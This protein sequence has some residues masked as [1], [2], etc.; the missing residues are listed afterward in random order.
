MAIKT[1]TRRADVSTG[2]DAGEPIRCRQGDEGWQLAVEVTQ[3]GEPLDLTGLTATLKA[4][5]PGYVSIPMTVSGSVAT[6]TATSELTARAGIWHPY[7]E[8]AQGETVVGTTSLL[9]LRVLSAADMDAEQQEQYIPALDQALSTATAASEAAQQAATQ[10]AQAVEDAQQAVTDAQ[11]AVS[12]AN[13][14]AQAANAAASA[15]SDAAAAA[16]GNV[17]VGSETGR[18]VAVDDAY[19]AKPR[20][21][22]VE[23]RTVN[24]LWVNPTGS[25]YGVTASETVDGAL[26]VSGTATTPG[27]TINTGYVY[28]LR[29]GSKITARCDRAAVA[30]MVLAVYFFDAD[31]SSVGYFDAIT[32]SQTQASYTVPSEAAYARCRVYVPNGVTVSGTYRVMLIEGS[33]APDCFV[34][35]GLSSVDE[36]SV[37]TAGKNLIGTDTYHGYTAA[38]VTATCNGDGSVTLTGTFTGGSAI[39]L[40]NVPIHY[41]ILPGT[42]TV[43]DCCDNDLVYVQVN[44]GVGGSICNSRDKQTGELG[45]A[46]DAPYWF[47]GVRPGFVGPATVYPQLELGSTAT[48]YEQPKYTSTPVDLDGHSLRSLPDGTCDELV[49]AMDGSC[50]IIQRVGAVMFD[51]SSDEGWV[52]DTNRIGLVNGAPGASSVVDSGNAY[53]DTIPVRNIV[54]AT[55]ITSYSAG[56]V[57]IRN[58]TQITSMET[59]KAWLASNPTTYVYPLAT[60][61]TIPLPA[62]TLPALPA[63]DATVWADT[64][65]I[66]TDATLTYERDVTIAFAQLEAEVAALKVNQATS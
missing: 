43:S 60:P 66:P 33:S 41:P 2:R 53:C 37:V 18:V 7:V 15:A 58:S 52:F 34:A 36:L 64:G 16:R 14:A 24:N 25:A 59:G 28:S 29:Q 51:G 26:Q 32:S 10:A 54:N 47:V 57:D 39:G 21:V 62:V 30:G 20:E 1:E 22:R 19:A 17:L 5:A 35:P 38:G 50:E 11:G 4:E 45:F 40:I 49:V 63:P 46:A 8:L 42:Y 65:A 12:A 27:A 61:Q 48:A 55:A 31:G 44:D 23:G 3:G 13:S 9:T 6:A 56:W